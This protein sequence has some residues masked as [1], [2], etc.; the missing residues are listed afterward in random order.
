MEW[1]IISCGIPQCS[2]Y[3]ARLIDENRLVSCID[4]TDDG[5]YEVTTALYKRHVN[6]EDGSITFD[7]LNKTYSTSWEART[8]A[9]RWLR[10]VVPAKTVIK[11][12]DLKFDPPH[13]DPEVAAIALEASRF[14]REHS[15]MR[16]LVSHWATVSARKLAMRADPVQ[17][18][19]D[20]AVEIAFRAMVGFGA[21]EKIW[22]GG[23]PVRGIPVRGEQAR[24]EQALRP[25]DRCV[26]GGVGCNSCEPQGRW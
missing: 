8:A 4:E 24:V 21:R 11:R 14:V 1:I 23:I 22:K 12:L 5:T 6:P 7:C 25:P 3:H 26:C 16:E 10:G 2:K 17:V 20:M 13:P 19:T 9:E 15:F 18:L